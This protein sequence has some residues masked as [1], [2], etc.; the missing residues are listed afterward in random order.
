MNY[1]GEL[2]ASDIKA[3]CDDNAVKCTI[4]EAARLIDQYDENGNGRL[5]YA[6]FCQL[7]L[8][9]THD[10]LRG[11][12]KSREAEY[13]YIKGAFLAKPVENALS[14]LF[15]KEIEYQ[16][17]IDEIKR[18]LNN[19]RDFSPQNCFSSIDK[20]YPYKKIDRNEIKDFVAEYYT[21][22]SEDDL[23]AIIRRCDTDEDEQI[24]EVEFKDVVQHY[25]INPAVNKF[26]GSIKRTNYDDSPSRRLT[27][28]NLYSRYNHLDKDKD[29]DWKD[30]YSTW[31]PK[32]NIRLGD[33][34]H[35]FKDTDWVSPYRYR[36]WSPNRYQ[37][38][39]N[40]RN[41]RWN[42]LL[43]NKYYSPYRFSWRDS[44][45]YRYSSY[46]QR[47]SW[48]G[49]YGTYRRNWRNGRLY[50]GSLFDPDYRFEGKISMKFSCLVKVFN[51]PYLSN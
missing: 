45:P 31:T 17:S 11:I 40:Y 2:D 39:G 42:S 18:E 41:S 12:V 38:W 9:S 34:R 30:L 49:L 27:W 25:H 37:R 23:D 28:G 19:K 46:P 3:F 44:S 29:L 13:R 5:S 43:Y 33:Y 35:T 10:H 36:Y 20:A 8:P 22:L 50:S 47:Y 6:E 24:S 4:A 14:V 1:I 26:L 32:R 48:G 16:R 21:I 15:Q 51:F 7:I